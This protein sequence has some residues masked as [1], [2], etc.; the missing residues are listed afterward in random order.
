[1]STGRV[2]ALRQ[3]APSLP[4]WGQQ[5]SWRGLAVRKNCGNRRRKLIN[6]RARHD[7]AVSASMRFLCDT[8]ESTALIFPELDV[9]VLAL[10]LQFFRLDDVVHFALRAPSLGI[11]TF[12]WKENPRLF[13]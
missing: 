6:T 12:K 13:N 8:Q 10:N 5:L 9:E 3:K 7:D 1:M 11:G 4:T 2:G